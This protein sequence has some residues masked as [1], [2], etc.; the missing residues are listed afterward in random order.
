MSRLISKRQMLALFMLFALTTL[1]GLPLAAQDSTE[2]TFGP[3]VFDL[4]TPTAGL[5][6]LSS[7]RATLNVSFDGTNSGQPQQWSRSYALLVTQTPAARQLTI[8]TSAAQVYMAD[9]NHTHYERQGSDPCVASAIAA[10][11]T[12]AQQWEPAG[13]L[14]SVIGADEVGTE[15]VNDVAA[16]H[17]TFDERAQ[18]AAG[19]AQSTGELWIASEGNYLVRYTLVTTGA[20]DYF[21]EG[22][23]G[24]LTWD[25]ELDDVNQPLTIAV[26]QDCPAGILD[27]P[28]M[29]DATNVV[30]VPGFTSYSTLSGLEDV[31]AFYQ[32]QVSASGGQLANPPQVTDRMALLGYTQGD[33]PILISASTDP[34]FGNTVVELQQMNDPAALAISA[35]VPDTA[36]TPAPTGSA[37]PSGNC[38]AGSNV[39]PILPDAT[40]MV[41]MPGMM[42]Y[43]TLTSV[44]DV[45]TFYKDQLSALGAQ[46]ISEPS[47]SD[48]M[49]MLNITQGGQT[50]SVTIFSEGG[51]TNVVIMGAIQ[52][53]A[54]AS[55]CNP[56]QPVATQAGTVPV[57]VATQPGT[58]AHDTSTA[59]SISALGNVNQ[60][61]GPGTNFARAGTLAGGTSA[62]VDGQAIGADG[63]IWWRLGESIWVR[64]DVVN[65]LGDCASVPFVQS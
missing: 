21:G 22:I 54:P 29:A 12:F 39:V 5:S 15:T 31:V 26:P 43:S 1:S 42:S 58:A 4:L 19:I 10:P 20:A 30:R 13:F 35:E 14:E 18:G 32:E 34:D 61:S 38:A 11:D 59:C 65:E 57:P 7:Y 25:Y 23:E 6:D 55:D 51:S 62:A 46:I 28:V 9:V 3:G 56:A 47:P 8:D 36:A 60:R 44:L 24:T 27:I 49:A 37:N 45:A 50:F 41:S 2:A 64:S 33:R 16:N 17:Y 48:Q 53:L 63:F 52:P 40:D